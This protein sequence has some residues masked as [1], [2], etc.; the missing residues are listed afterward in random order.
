MGLS[1]TDDELQREIAAIPAFQQ[2]GQFRDDL[3]RSAL[4][5]NRLTPAAFETSKRVEITM[6]KVEGLFAAGALVPET[7]AQELFRVAS[8][9]VR[10]LVVTAD[11][12]RVKADP[13]TEGEILAK[14][15]QAKERFRTPARVKLA[16]AA[17]TPDIF[18]REVQPSEAEIKAFHET[19]PTGSAPRSSG[20]SRG[21]SCPSER[22]TG[23]RC[24][25]RRRRSS[26]RR[27]RGKPNSMPRRRRIPA[28]KAGRRGSRARTPASRS[29]RRCFRPPWT[30]WSGR[31]SFPAAS[32]SPA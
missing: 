30:R 1:A 24:G 16:V 3:Y 21:S 20:W 9:K 27:P 19:T 11:P 4:S 29:P 17:F 14:Y 2:N 8:R 32:S 31:S 6:K 5:F 18:G 10:L 23:T 26:P 7:E 25:R 22:R 15:E 28:G 13:P 12:G